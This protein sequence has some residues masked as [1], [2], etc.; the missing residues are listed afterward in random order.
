MHR[1]PVITVFAVLFLLAGA[2]LWTIAGVRLVAPGSVSLMAGRHFMYG[3][4]LAGPYMTLL[5]GGGYLLVGSGLLRLHNWARWTAMMVMALGV[6]F[7]VPRISSA[8]LGLAILWYGLQIAL[9]VAAAWYLA[10]SAAVV[11]A[12]TTKAKQ[13]ATDQSGFH[14]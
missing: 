1:P 5:V 7:L 14:G 13:S 12:F 2:Y 4:E 11:D 8:E 10:Q 9:R 6:G 3:L